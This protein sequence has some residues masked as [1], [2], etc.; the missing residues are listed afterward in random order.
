MKHL[1]KYENVKSKGPSVGDFVICK[2]HT[3]SSYIGRKIDIFIKTNI[4]EIIAKNWDEFEVKF[5][6]VPELLN[7]YMIDH[8]RKN[9]IEHYSKNKEDLEVY[10]D[11][12]KYNL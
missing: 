5:D 4:G 8:Y 12:N 2:S 6:N 1:R 9:E 7:D 11:A 3:N 10:I